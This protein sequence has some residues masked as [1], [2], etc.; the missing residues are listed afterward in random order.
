[1]ILH[2]ILKYKEGRTE[3][4]VKNKSSGLLCRH[5]GE[6]CCLTLDELSAN[7]NS[8]FPVCKTEIIPGGTAVGNIHL[9]Y[10]VVDWFRVTSAPLWRCSLEFAGVVKNPPANAGDVGGVRDV[11]VIPG[12]GRSPGG[13]NGNPLQHSC[14]V[15]NYSQGKH[16]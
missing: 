12:S 3:D 9:K 1:M 13:G 8:S 6:H 2:T 14:L 16:A 4:G 15:A 5:R 7:F 11:S 10:S